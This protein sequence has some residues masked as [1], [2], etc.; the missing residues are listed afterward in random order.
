M[1]SNTAQTLSD[2]RRPVNAQTG[3]TTDLGPGIGGLV[4]SYAGMN[5]PFR[6]LLWWLGYRFGWAPWDTGR[7]IPMLVEAVEGQEG[8]VPG[9]SHAADASRS[10][11]GGTRSEG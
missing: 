7:P 10:A 4:D 1:F 9:A 3:T 2:R 11:P 6:R 8:L 5:A